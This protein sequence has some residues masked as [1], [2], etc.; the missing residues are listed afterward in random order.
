MPARA[1]IIGIADYSSY[2]AAAGLPP[3]T[4]DL[5]GPVNDART[6]AVLARLLGYRPEDIRVLTSA[7]ISA[8]DVAPL[9][10]GRAP[11]DVSLQGATFGPATRAAIEE[12][13]AW[14]AEGLTDPVSRGILS[15]SGHGDVRDGEA[16]L[17][18]ADTGAGLAG[19]FTY[20]ELLERL[21][22][23]ESTNLTVFLDACHVAGRGRGTL[24]GGTLAGDTPRFQGKA[25]VYAACEP[26]EV[27]WE[28]HFGGR[29]HGVFTWALCRVLERWERHDGEGYH[30]V[31]ISNRE[32]VR[33][34]G[35]LLHAMAFDQRPRLETDPERAGKAAFQ[36]PFLRDDDF[37]PS[38]GDGKE[39]DPSMGS[40]FQGT[41]V[42]G[43]S[44]IQLYSNSG[45]SNNVGWLVAVGD[46]N[47]TTGTFTWQANRSY[48][49]FVPS[50]VSSNYGGF[51][52]ADFWGEVDTTSELPLPQVGQVIIELDNNP[53]TT[54]EYHNPGQDKYYELKQVHSSGS[55]FV[56]WMRPEL[57]GGGDLAS[58][59]WFSQAIW[60]GQQWVP[61]AW[62]MDA[63]AGDGVMHF[64]WKGTCNPAHMDHAS[65][66]RDYVR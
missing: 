44:L 45:L 36:F 39:I 1:L 22:G 42:S 37:D 29:W 10:T 15:W 55:Q 35:D 59:A 13:L 41:A 30:Y 16:V 57:D 5:R 40:A 48:W 61:R 9:F 11:E 46:S 18:P 62:F 4:S 52:T 17:C 20:G 34:V 64:D 43:L 65:K 38:G 60:N 51:P 58:V 66:I 50:F 33:R 14:L 19:A 53:F 6:V 49:Y 28:H 21:G 23:L 3:G 7:P 12:G 56:G 54:V 31:R 8:G 32:L 26:D 63:S 25:V 24:S 2:D 27:A 47:V